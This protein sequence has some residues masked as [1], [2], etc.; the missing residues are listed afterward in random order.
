[1]L[2]EPSA[3]G[4]TEEMPGSRLSALPRHTSNPAVQAVHTFVNE[5]LRFVL[6]VHAGTHQNVGWGWD[7]RWRSEEY[8]GWEER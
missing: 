2:H 8:K 5:T 6:Q 1:M 3:Q 7:G 4:Y